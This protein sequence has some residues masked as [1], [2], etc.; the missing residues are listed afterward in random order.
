MVNKNP[1][2]QKEE[3]CYSRKPGK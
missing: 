3:N 1:Q 2:H